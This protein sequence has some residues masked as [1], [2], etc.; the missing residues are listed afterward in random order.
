MPIPTPHINAKKE[1]IAD[2]LA[3]IL[4]AEDESYQVIVNFDQAFI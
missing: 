4:E 2:K 1:D 3:E